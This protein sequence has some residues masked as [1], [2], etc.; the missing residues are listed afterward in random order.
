MKSGEKTRTGAS[1]WGLVA[2]SLLI[3]GLLPPVSAGG[4]TMHLIRERVNDFDPGVR[5]NVCWRRTPPGNP[6]LAAGPFNCDPVITAVD[7]PFPGGG[8]TGEQ[9]MSV[10]DRVVVEGSVVEVRIRALEAGKDAGDPAAG[11]MTVNREANEFYN[12][13][14]GRDAEGRLVLFL[15]IEVNTD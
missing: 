15:D 4:E 9:L 14:V 12:N 1:F 6:F 10:V 8:V 5:I 2:V 7:P 3:V 11:M 13:Y